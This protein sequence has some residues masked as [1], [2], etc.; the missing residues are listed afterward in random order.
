[1]LMLERFWTLAIMV[2]QMTRCTRHSRVHGP[3]PSGDAPAAIRVQLV[4]RQRAQPVRP[5]AAV[6]DTRTTS[7]QLSLR[8]GVHRH[9]VPPSVTPSL[10]RP[11]PPAPFPSV[12]PSL[13][14]LVPPHP[15][16]LSPFPSVTLSLPH[17]VPPSPRR[18]RGSSC[19]FALEVKTPS[20]SLAVPSSSRVDR[21]SRHTAHSRLP[22]DRPRRRRV[23]RSRWRRSRSPT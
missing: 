7:D 1:M 6:V 10:P 23:A 5:A 17:L 9:S 21:A 4:L 3:L 16:P 12:T 15:S 2:V 20:P 8:A 19:V 22:S 13:R 14:H 11:V 18:L